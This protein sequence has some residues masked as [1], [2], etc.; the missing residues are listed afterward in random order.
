VPA[1]AKEAALWYE[2]SAEAG[3][4]KAQYTLGMLFLE[5][6]G[7]EK[8]LKK[9]EMWMH[10]AAKQGNQEAKN[11]LATMHAQR[12]E[13]DQAAEIWWELAKAGELNAQCN[14]GMCYMRGMGRPQ[15]L[16]EAR[17]WLSKSAAQGH[18]MATQALMQLSAAD[19]D[20]G[21]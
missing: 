21:S 18:Q 15:D 17:K 10:F 3:F 9:A 8:D 11:N 4:P 13:V 2:R 5:G 19:T 16:Q 12:G 7:R 6:T 1:D 20:G 14:I